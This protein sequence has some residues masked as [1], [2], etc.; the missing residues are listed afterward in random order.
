[1]AGAVV[2]CAPGGPPDP[3]SKLAQEIND[4]I[5]RVKEAG[6]GGIKGLK[7]RFAE[8]VAPGASGPGT[9]A[10][11]RHDEQIKTQQRGLRDRLNN[12]NKNNCGGKVPI[13]ADAWDWATKK[14]P[15]L[16]EWKANNPVAPRTA[17][18]SALDWKALEKATGF[19]GVALVIYLIISE[20]SRI[21]IPPRNL[22]PVP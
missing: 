5:N 20:G 1:M 21:L 4:F 8:Q 11:V 2:N 6:A 12:F 18:S 7:Q 22:I 15:A 14:P 13:P 10:W 16:A 19:T 3:C 9:P 17:E